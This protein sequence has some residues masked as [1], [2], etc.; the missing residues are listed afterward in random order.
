VAAGGHRSHRRLIRTLPKRGYL[1]EGRVEYG[2]EQS[3]LDGGDSRAPAVAALRQPWH[4]W[5]GLAIFGF[6]LLALAFV[7]AQRT[8]DAATME[9][10]EATDNSPV[11]AVLPFADLSPAGNHG[12]FADGVSEEII[13][14]L[15]EYRELRVI[16]RT[17]SFALRNSNLGSQELSALLGA[18][19]L[20]E[21]SV[22]TD[23]Q[24]VRVSVRLINRDGI[25]LWG[26]DFDR[27][28][29]E[30]I[31][32]QQEIADVVASF[33]VPVVAHE[34]R[35]VPLP[36]FASYREYL[37][38]KDQLASRPAGFRERSV[39]HFSRAITLDPDFAAPY[40]GRAVALFFSAQVQQHYQTPLD[41]AWRDVELALQLDPQLAEGYAAKALLMEWRE[42]RKL[43][44]RE[45]LLRKALELNPSLPDAW[46]WLSG[47]LVEQNRQV[48]SL[49]ALQQGARFDPLAPAINVNLA[50]DMARTG[51][52]NDALDQLRR[53][54]QLPQISPFVAASAIA[55]MRSGGNLQEAWAASRQLLLDTIPVMGNM[56]WSLPLAEVYA[57]LQM[58]EQ[59]HLW[60]NQSIR[61]WPDSHL[62]AK[63]L[64][65]F[66]LRYLLGF[67]DS[68]H[69]MQE[70]M[71]SA[72][73]PPQ[74]LPRNS[75]IN[76]GELLTLAGEHEAAADLL[77]ELLEQR[78]EGSGEPQAVLA[79]A[80]SWMQSGKMAPA[81]ER[82]QAL[83]AVMQQQEQ[84]HRLHLSDDLAEAALTALLSGN[85]PLALERLQRAVQAGWRQSAQLTQDPRWAAAFGPEFEELRLFISSDIDRQRQEI[86]AA[87]D[88]DGFLAEVEGLLAAATPAASSP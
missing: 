10:G 26:E 6:A 63:L 55:L 21:G 56:S 80:W 49:Q 38:G 33:I 70:L 68:L 24:A 34:P 86:I 87:D 59:A 64:V 4:S 13:V 37:L 36:D 74:D 46:N 81:D 8:E 12:W 43:K 85:R 11:L 83:E 66:R 44:Q 7:I 60:L 30:I 23:D 65:V 31:E 45:A 27:Q 28:A 17:S 29:D 82:L 51:R 5:I 39:E 78:A 41:Q 32:L 53:L 88:P 62:A 18:S 84:M 40:A 16:G 42:P 2:P 3:A 79:L 25:R 52:L 72:R 57:Q 67:Q 19:Y 1:L 73:V 20:L 35:A 14:R 75:Q 61:D 15:A 22:R 48:E 69:L 76:Y 58:D 9:P 54:E 50:F 47:V 77:V 71:D